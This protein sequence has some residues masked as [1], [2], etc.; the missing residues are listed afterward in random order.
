MENL[1]SR[2]PKLLFL[3]LTGVI[4]I[5]LLAYSGLQLLEFM[6]S[7]AFCGRLCHEVMYPEYT[8]HQA[9]PH[10]RVP[11]AE[12]HVGSG[13]DYMVRTKVSG[14]PLIFATLLNSYHR[15]V[16]TPVLNL[17]PARD[18]CEQCHRP[19]KFTGDIIRVSTSFSQ[20][21][22]NT[23]QV[24][25]RVFKVGGG[26]SDIARDIHWHIGAKV[27]YLPLDDKRQDIGWVGVET[28]NNKLTEYVDPYKSYQN[29]TTSY[30][31]DNKRLMDCMDCHNRATHVFRSPEELINTKLAQGK[32]DRSIPFIKK[33]GL[34]ALDPASSSLA[35][36]YS[37]VEAI[38]DYYRTSMPK[39]YETKA[40]AIDNAVKELKDAARLTT[41]PDM[42]V[43]WNIYVDNVGHQNSPGCFRC[44]GKMVAI[45]GPKKD[46]TVDASCSL[47]HYTLAP[48]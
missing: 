18:T 46:K 9:S 47:C 31:Q 20:D 37:K 8:A 6:D 38:K 16:Q 24:D 23:R 3:M 39:V 13:A 43:D 25:S 33:K 5:V 42:K 30:I 2:R 45:S 44:H 41:F 10:S 11:C 35:Q 17:R 36:A 14:V 29:V 4:G 26:E 19:E 34:A 40:A 7:T 1:R 27:W 21:E 12:C 48:K 15:P 32:I 22:N 28:P